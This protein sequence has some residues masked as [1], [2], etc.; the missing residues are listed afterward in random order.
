MKITNEPDSVMATVE[1]ETHA[2]QQ[3]FIASLRSDGDRRY[4]NRDAETNEQQDLSE[5]ITNSVKLL[6]NVEIT[7]H[8]SSKTKGMNE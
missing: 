6:L 2:G 4:W 3:T 5:I 7:F 8:E 1:L